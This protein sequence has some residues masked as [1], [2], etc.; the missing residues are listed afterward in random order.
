MAG[1]LYP[2]YQKFYSALCSLERFKKNPIFLIIFHAWIHSFP[3]IG[4]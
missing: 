3:S 1:L 4:M 2:A